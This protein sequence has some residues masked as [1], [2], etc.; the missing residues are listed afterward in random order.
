MEI[1]HSKERDLTVEEQQELEK[2]RKVI[3]RASADG[4]I[5][6][7][8]RDQISSAMRA[9][10]KVTYEELAL[11]RTLVHEKVSQGELALDYESR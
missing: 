11:I 6:K 3:E 8:E 4:V 1:S 2:L 5:T 10:G 9:D 7:A